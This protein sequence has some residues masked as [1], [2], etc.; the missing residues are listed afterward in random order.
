MSNLLDLSNLAPMSDS[1]IQAKLDE[2]ERRSFERG[3]KAGL[4]E[5][6]ALRQSVISAVG[7]NPD[8]IKVEDTRSDDSD[9]SLRAEW[10]CSPDLRSEFGE[11][12]TRFAAFKK[13]QLRGMVHVS[14]PRVV[15][16]EKVRVDM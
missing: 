7:S 15:R 6:T 10:S 3:R 8:L 4:A 14:T 1:E 5:A 9:A 13:Y 11:D 16:G 12:F 2:L